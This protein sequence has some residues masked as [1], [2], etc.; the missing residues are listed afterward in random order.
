MISEFLTHFKLC[1]YGGIGRR[2]GLKIP[3]PK[4]RIGSNPITRTI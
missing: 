3:R 1:E 4:K 2:K